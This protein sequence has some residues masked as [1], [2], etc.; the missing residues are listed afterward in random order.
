MKAIAVL[1]ILILLFLVSAC[2]KTKPVSF[3]GQ[4]L[5]TK[6]YPVVF[7]R[8]EIEIYQPGS[9]G[10]IG[11][12]A[13]SLS[14]SSTAG[15]DAGGY[16]SL[17]FIP[18]TTTFIIFTGTNSNSLTLS[19]SFEDTSFP[20]FS[21]RNFPDRGYDPA[22]PIFIGKSIDTAIIKVNLLTDLTDADTIGLQAYSIS[23]KLDK[24][25][26]GI[27]A[28][29]GSVIILDTISNMLFTDFNCT[30]NKFTNTLY[31][32]KKFTT[33]WGYKTISSVSSPSPYQLSATDETKTELMFYFQK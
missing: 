17:S 31:A 23:G 13:S 29:A 21:R 14:S 32:G 5:L 27:T 4:L 7:S 30:E 10:V 25:Y 6:K 8:R 26:T 12:P 15:T 16:F 20:R 3:S 11:I 28:S 19:N 24:E 22:K 1:E 33:I 9:P 18:G 2:K